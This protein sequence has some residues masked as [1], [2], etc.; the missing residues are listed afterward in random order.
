[1][2][3]QLIADMIWEICVEYIVL[4]HHAG[5]GG[6]MEHQFNHL[7]EQFQSYLKC[8]I[9]AISSKLVG[10][11]DLCDYLC[12]IGSSQENRLLTSGVMQRIATF[13]SVEGVM[14]YLVQ[15]YCS[16]LNCDILE[17]IVEKYDL[18]P[19]MTYPSL[20]RTF[21]AEH[22]IGDLIKVRSSCIMNN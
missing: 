11:R 6:S 19:R 3:V 12:S 9:D 10:P 14:Q 5:P 13:D 22:S 15:K 21:F 1:M 2:W 16:F 17:M 7:R 8:I 4:L 20:L 18:Q